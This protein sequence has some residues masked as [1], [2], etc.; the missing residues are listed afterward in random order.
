[1]DKR[2]YAKANQD[3]L[4]EKAKEEG[5]HSLPKGVLYRVIATGEGNGKK[6]TSGNI[7][8]VHY[9]GRTIDGKTFD[10]SVGGT[11]LAIRLRDLIVG[12]II[13]LQ[14]MQM[15]DRWEVYIPAE[16]GYGKFSQPGIPANSTLIFDIE[17]L[18]IA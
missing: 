17:L 9:T 14:Q 5:I 1:M 10:S 3:W 13:A 15:G 18:G 6:P 12:W 16:V 11:P 2:A 7:V 4:I 8:T